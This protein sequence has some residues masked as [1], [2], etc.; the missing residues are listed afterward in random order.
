MLG[1]SEREL[2]HTRQITCRAYRRKDGLYE[3]EATVA[4]EK[5]QEMVFRSREPIRPGELI[6]H[7]TIAFLIDQDF[8]I[9]DV[10]ARMM[11]VPWP[12]CPEAAA[13]Y[14]RL[15][16]LH[17][18]PGFG[19]QVRERVGGTQ[20][21]AH[22]TDLITQVGNTYTQASWPDR[23]ARQIAIDPDPRRWPDA[24]AVAFVGE[25]LAWRRDGETLRG[26]YPELADE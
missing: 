2:V 8:T 25:C 1:K 3:V 12:V 4:D 7:M 24:R 14:R 11:A 9:L 26:E 21:C 5:A 10:E 13:A 15:I 19:R 20:G 18:G 17:I 22:L 23:V 16:G 6:H